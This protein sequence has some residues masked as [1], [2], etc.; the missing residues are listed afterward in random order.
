M[1]DAVNLA[2]RL[3][4]LTKFYG[5]PILISETTRRLAPGFAAI[6]VDVIAVKGKTEAVRTHGLLG[7][8]DVAESEEFQRL[9]A[10]HDNML[11]AYRARDWRRAKTLAEACQAVRPDLGRLYA[12]YLE[13]IAEFEHAP[14]GADWDGVYIAKEK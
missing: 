5:V 1:G 4:S 12:V 8:P 11:R 2:S 10:T 3:E 13:R 9:A 14:P 6:E 7:Q